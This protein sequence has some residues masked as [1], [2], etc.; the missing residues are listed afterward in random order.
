M[1]HVQCGVALLGIAGKRHTDRQING[2]AAPAPCAWLPSNV[3][4]WRLR[5]ALSKGS[6][7]F[8]R[9]DSFDLLC[10]FRWGAKHP[11]KHVSFEVCM[12]N[13][14]LRQAHHCF[15]FAERAVKDI[16]SAKNLAQME[17]AWIAF[18]NST[19]TMYNKLEAGSKGFCKTEPWFGRKSKDLKDSQELNYIHHARN[20]DEHGII[21]LGEFSTTAIYANR[22]GVFKQEGSLDINDTV[23]KS[24]GLLRTVQENRFF[25]SDVCNLKH[26]LRV[27]HLAIR[28]R[29]YK[30]LQHHSECQTLLWR[31]FES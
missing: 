6:R 10:G 20:A 4:G 17:S 23:A 19:G 27:L 13:R 12:D 21:E 26:K 24:D 22:A 7:S 3:Q 2:L 14:H 15:R 31:V 18:L 8:E 5:G 1:L 25:L 29:S 30:E 16:S 11:A 9:L 28:V